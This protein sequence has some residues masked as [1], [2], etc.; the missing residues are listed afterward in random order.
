MHK[1]RGMRGGGAG[2]SRITDV[3]QARKEKIKGLREGGG[4]KLR[5]TRLQRLSSISCDPLFCYSARH[6]NWEETSCGRNRNNWS[7]AGC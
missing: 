6:E 7:F 4:G 2:W 5:C 3:R 1:G